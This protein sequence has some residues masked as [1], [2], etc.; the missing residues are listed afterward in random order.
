L[1]LL[2]LAL[3]FIANEKRRQESPVCQLKNF[4]LCTVTQDEA[5]ASIRSDCYRSVR[6][7][8]ERTSVSLFVSAFIQN[9]LHGY[10]TEKQFHW[11]RCLRPWGTTVKLDR[12]QMPI[13]S[14]PQFLRERNPFGPFSSCRRHTQHT[15]MCIV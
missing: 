8:A 2:L 7:A 5:M 3:S 4:W 6:R 11:S 1:V 13:K 10:D 9:P 15:Y 12:R 14:S